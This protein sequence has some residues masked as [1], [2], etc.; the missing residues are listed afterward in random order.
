MNLE[1]QLFIIEKKLSLSSIS[2]WAVSLFIFVLSYLSFGALRLWF[3]GGPVSVEKCSG[4]KLSGDALRFFGS[5]GEIGGELGNR[6]A[7]P[8][9][10]IGFCLL[11]S[12]GWTPASLCCSHRWA[13]P[14]WQSERSACFVLDLAVSRVIFDSP[15]S[16]SSLAR[17]SQWALAV[18]KL[19]LQAKSRNH[20]L[21]WLRTLPWVLSFVGKSGTGRPVYNAFARWIF[22]QNF[23]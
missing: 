17:V 20:P 9:R 10:P 22:S 8:E 18:E 19:S 23:S 21:T 3:G 14:A 2:I 12:W 13:L 7:W 11:Q 6:G 5:A 1:L 16:L 4:W 15:E